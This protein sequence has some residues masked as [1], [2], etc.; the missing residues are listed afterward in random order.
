MEKLTTADTEVPDKELEPGLLES[1][2]ED[3]SAMNRRHPAQVITSLS[4]SDQ[5]CPPRMA[6]SSFTPSL[7]DA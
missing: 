5:A 3:A 2:Y 4:S 1:V 6:A 7:R